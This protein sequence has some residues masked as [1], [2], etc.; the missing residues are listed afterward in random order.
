MNT[1][2]ALAQAAIY[3]YFFCT[4][5]DEHMFNGEAIIGRS[6]RERQAVNYENRT[7]ILGARALFVWPHEELRVAAVVC[8]CD[9]IVFNCAGTCA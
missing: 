2:F 3:F 9:P 4:P 8:V 7:I 6:E 1:F 5:I